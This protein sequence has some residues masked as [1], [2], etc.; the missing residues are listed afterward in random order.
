MCYSPVDFQLVGNGELIF[1]TNDRRQCYNISVNISADEICDDFS[2]E[3]IVPSLRLLTGIG[4]ISVLPSTTLLSTSDNEEP[5]CGMLYY[6]C[7]PL[8]KCKAA[9]IF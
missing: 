4:D 6:Y 9:F 5:E 7:V 8:A 2:M 3:M 1:Q